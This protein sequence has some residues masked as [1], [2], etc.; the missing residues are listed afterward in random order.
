MQYFFNQGGKVTLSGVGPTSNGTTQTTDWINMLSGFTYTW[1]IGNFNTYSSNTLVVNLANEPSPYSANYAKLWTYTS[2]T[3]IYFSV[4]Y[5]DSHVGT[6]GG[7]DSVNSGAGF[8]VQQ[9]YATGAFSGYQVYSSSGASSWST[10][11]S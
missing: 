8:T 5:Y 4:E 10:T 11:T 6:G 2:G 9:Y 1:N 7:P 3:T